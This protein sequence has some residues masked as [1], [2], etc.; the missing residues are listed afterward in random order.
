MTIRAFLLTKDRDEICRNCKNYNPDPEIGG[1]YGLCDHA[2]RKGFSGKK[3][4]KE[5]NQ[6]CDEEMT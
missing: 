3:V 4:V 5:A 2:I 1:M 6:Y